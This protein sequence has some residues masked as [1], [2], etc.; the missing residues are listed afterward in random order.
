MK[1]PEKCKTI[2]ENLHCTIIDNED[3][4]RGEYHLLV[5]TQ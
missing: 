3:I 2:Q 4:V 5:E 1:C